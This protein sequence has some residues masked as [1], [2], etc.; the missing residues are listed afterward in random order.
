M[1]IKWRKLL[2]RKENTVI[3]YFYGS[4][5]NTI[6]NENIDYPFK[7]KIKYINKLKGWGEGKRSCQVLEIKFLLL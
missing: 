1:T 5:T 6:N 3:V 7:K 2:H 4:Q